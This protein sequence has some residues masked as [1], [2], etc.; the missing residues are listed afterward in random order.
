MKRVQTIGDNKFYV[1]NNIFVFFEGVP[2]KLVLDP[3]IVR[4]GG[5]FG[6]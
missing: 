6:T 3:F 4:W 5:D 2:Y 1:Y